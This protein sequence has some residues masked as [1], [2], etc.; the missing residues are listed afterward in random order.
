MQHETFKNVKRLRRLLTWQQSSSLLHSLRSHNPLLAQMNS[1]GQEPPLD[2]R[3]KTF[4]VNWVSDELVQLMLSWRLQTAKYR[5]LPFK[6]HK[7][8]SVSF[9]LNKNTPQRERER[10]SIPVLIIRS[11][12]VKQQLWLYSGGG[13]VTAGLQSSLLPGFRV[14]MWPLKAAG[15]LTW[16]SCS[17]ITVALKAE[18]FPGEERA[19]AR[20]WK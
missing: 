17:E 8:P 7:E 16:D 2:D 14:W 10:V 4:P 15:G 11:R 1:T 6:F 18:A 12:Q 13:S 19:N 5:S 3:R 9:V 20:R